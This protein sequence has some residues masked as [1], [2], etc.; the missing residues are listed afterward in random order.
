MVSRLA[1]S[2]VGPAGVV[3]VHVGL[4]AESQ[5]GQAEIVHDL[6]VLVFQGPPKALHL[7]VV[8]AAALAVHADAYASTPDSGGLWE[9]SSTD[10]DISRV[11]HAEPKC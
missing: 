3:E 7:G 11:P 4:H 6:D 5:L 1:E 2:G 10:T 8:E 9:V